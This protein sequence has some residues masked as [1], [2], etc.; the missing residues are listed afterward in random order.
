MQ[1]NDQSPSIRNIILIFCLLLILF[2]AAF[3]FLLGER[4]VYYNCR[5]IEFLPDVPSAVR[6]ECNEMIKEQYEKQNNN[7]KPLISV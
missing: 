6:H 1:N 4:V 2:L 3:T 7:L 5:D